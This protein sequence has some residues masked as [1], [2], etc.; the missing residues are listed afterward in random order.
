M[1]DVGE[2]MGREMTVALAR[3]SAMTARRRVGPGVER[4]TG[5]SRINSRGRATSAWAIRAAGAC[6]PNRRRS[7][8]GLRV[9]EPDQL[10]GFVG[11]LRLPRLESL[12]C[13]TTSSR[14][15]SS[16]SSAELVEHADA[17][18]DVGPPP[19]E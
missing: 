3:T 19:P 18:A 10:E 12:G 13:E 6:H 5:S 17:A 15:S 11:A 14:R 2:D 16:R 8:A 9:A 7:I 1:L 4:L